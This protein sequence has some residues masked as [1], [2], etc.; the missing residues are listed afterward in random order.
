MTNKS[1]THTTRA[2]V[3][4]KKEKKEACDKAIIMRDSSPA[5]SSSLYFF[6]FAI[7]H[8][9]QQPHEDKGVESLQERADAHLPDCTPPGW[10]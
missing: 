2:T 9:D 1:Q 8:K 3:Y 5:G 4:R 10:N 6:W 7:L